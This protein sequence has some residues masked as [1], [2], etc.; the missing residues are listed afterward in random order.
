MNSKRFL[1][2]VVLCAILLLPILS[3]ADAAWEPD[4]DFFMQ[5]A[6]ECTYEYRTYIAQS[7]VVVRD[8]PDGKPVY[9][10]KDEG[11]LF[12]YFIYTDANGKRWAATDEYVENEGWLTGWVL[13]DKLELKYDSQSFCED[14]RSE[15]VLPP[16]DEYYLPDVRIEDEIEAYVWT[17]PNSGERL[18]TVYIQK[19]YPMEFTALY[20]DELGRNWGLCDYYAAWRDFWV[21]L[22]DPEKI[23]IPSPPTPAPAPTTETTSTPEAATEVTETPEATLSPSAVQTQSPAAAPTIVPAVRSNGLMRH[24][25]LPLLLVGG[26]FIVTVIVLLVVFLPKLRRK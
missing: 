4:N 11:E 18:G 26:V 14:H 9:E 22:D 21:F 15:L 6:R 12:V 10:V 5:H 20:T 23:N 16:K 2:T 8:E 19:D 25:L 7:A 13:M 1:L 3:L 24:L 17:Y